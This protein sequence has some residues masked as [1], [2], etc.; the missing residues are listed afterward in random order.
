ME[1]VILIGLPASGKS[2]FF[3]ERFAR[4]HDHVSKDLLRSNR[5]PQRRQEQLVAEPLAAGRSVVIDNTNPSVAVRAPLIAL[6][7]AHGAEVVGYVFVTE[8]ADALRRNRAREGH[9]R[10]P[11]VAIFTARQR[12]EM[13]TPAEGFDRLFEVKMN[14]E[15][16]TF[17][18]VP[19]L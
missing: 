15:E 4:T 12:F 11:A 13:P 5:R 9:A 14:E 7:K 18:V 10:V 1:C 16:R 2:T 19:L 8:A 3:R 6:A 17:D